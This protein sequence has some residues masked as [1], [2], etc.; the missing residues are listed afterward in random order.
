[1]EL[2]VGLEARKVLK[3]RLAD[4]TKV[5]NKIL[6]FQNHRGP[7]ARGIWAKNEKPYCFRS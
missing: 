4:K 7:D 5:I 3:N 1:M 2:P 6:D